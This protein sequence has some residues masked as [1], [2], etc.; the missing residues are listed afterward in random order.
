M[1]TL[2]LDDDQFK[3]RL[4]GDNYINMYVHTSIVRMLF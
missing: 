3:V 2:T 1:V 4:K